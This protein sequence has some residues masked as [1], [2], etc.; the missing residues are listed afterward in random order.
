VRE[1]YGVSPTPPR[2][3][4]LI[5]TALVCAWVAPAALRAGDWPQ[6]LGP[7]RDGVAA[8]PV[9]GTFPAGGPKVVWSAK[10]GQGFS[11]PVVAG[12]SVVIFHR[13]GN[14]AVVRCLDA[15][16][17]TE[18]WASKYPTDYRDD[19]G[20][21][22]GP[23][24]T[25]AISGGRVYTFG[26]EGML[27]CWNLADG[28]KAWSVDTRAQFHADK[29]FFGVACSPLVEGD[30]VVLNVGGKGGAGV[31][32]FDR[33]DGRV[34][35]KATGD[36]AGYAS[37]VAATLGGRRYVLSF[38]RAG[39][40]GID[41]PTGAVKFSFPWRSRS[42]ASVNAATP[43]VVGDDVFLSASYGTG[44][45]LLHVGADGKPGEVWSGDESLSNHYATSVYRDGM[46]YG[47]DGRQEMTPR[48]RCVE[49]KTGKVRWTQ[50]DFGA[51]TLMRA[52]DRLVILTEKGELVIAP[53]T[54]E[55]FRPVARAR[56]LKSTCRA[57]AALAGG[58]L[59]ARDQETLLCVDLR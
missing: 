43:L 40:A 26:A 24:A 34:R 31:V 59:Y 36:E 32:A 6:F 25:P 13:V 15:A 55:G 19:F 49:W 47:F 30:L 10:V 21:D 57:H 41:P 9:A 2:R 7:N 38:N 22:E 50:E 48:L 44:A 35:W 23:R 20:F 1:D 18:K 53:A 52:G 37:P 58:M 46:L 11:G 16:T 3:A 4:R 39:L 54:P 45:V 12:G 33:G 5:V 17:G 51:G 8:D 14:D 28:A 29:G 42:H 56:V 27:A